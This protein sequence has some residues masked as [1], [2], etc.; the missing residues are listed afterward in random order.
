LG[1]PDEVRLGFVA[2]DLPPETQAI[3]QNGLVT[4]YSPDVLTALL[5]A[6]VRV[7]EDRVKV[8]EAAK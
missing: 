5:F 7:L 8:L 4:G 3:D 2:E 1:S 6:K